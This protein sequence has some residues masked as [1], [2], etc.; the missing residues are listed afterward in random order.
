MVAGAAALVLVGG[1]LAFWLLRDSTPDDGLAAAAEVMPAD[2]GVVRFLDR[3]AAAERLGVDDIGHGASSAELREYVDAVVASQWT[4]TPLSLYLQVMQEAPFSELD[5]DWWASVEVGEPGAAPPVN[6]Y[7]MDDG[8][9]LGEVADA[10]ADAGFEES[11]QDGNRRFTAEADLADDTGLVDG[12]LPWAELLDV[13]VVEEQHLLVVG[14]ESAAVL[15]VVSGDADSLADD[16]GLAALRERTESPEYALVF[17]GQDAGCAGQVERALGGA[18]PEIME[19]VRED[20]GLDDLGSPDARGLFVVPD[21]E[22]DGASAVAVLTFGSGDEAEADAEAREST[23]QNGSDPVTRTPYSDILEVESVQA[24]DDVVIVET[25]ADP[26]QVL[27]AS[28][29]GFGP[30]AC[31]D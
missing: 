5:V 7:R 24:E 16:D 31:T 21:A 19:R 8:L 23:L 12:E 22:G 28:D 26:A 6:V 2:T 29:N 17:L 4:G 27:Q 11:D 9:D 1:L 25:G 13:T 10:L 30:L 18:T 3:D 14:S 15:D 20:L